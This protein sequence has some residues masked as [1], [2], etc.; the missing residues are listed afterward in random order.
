MS[1]EKKNVCFAV[2]LF[3]PTQL[4]IQGPFFFGLNKVIFV[5]YQILQ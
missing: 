3:S 4:L 5:K 2:T 1:I